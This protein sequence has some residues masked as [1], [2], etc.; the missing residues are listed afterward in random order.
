MFSL[1]KISLANRSVVALLT[2]ILAVFGF[3]SVGSLKQELF[4]SLEFPQAAIVTTYPGASP[5]V[6]DTQVSRLIE[7]SVE[8]LEGV[9]TTSSTSQSSLSTV[10]VTFDF[11]ITSA[12]VTESLNAALDSVK[13]N[14]PTG[15]N[16]RVLS[17]GLDTI[18]VLVLSVA[19]DSGDNTEI[20]KLLPDLAPTL[21]KKVPGVKDVQIGGIRE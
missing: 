6:M 7:S 21:F 5:E 18:P 19:S 20:S 16:A 8:S 1:S 3:I 13:A 10:R 17:G 15:A 9:T 4:P 12:K 14:L 2:S 11:G